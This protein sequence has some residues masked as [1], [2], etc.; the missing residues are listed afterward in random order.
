MGETARVLE[1]IWGKWE[2]KYFSEN[3]KYDLTA[4]STKPPDGQINAVMRGIRA[5]IGCPA[6][7]VRYQ[8]QPGF[9]LRDAIE[10]RSSDSFRMSVID[11]APT[12]AVPMR[13]NCVGRHV[14]R[15]ATA[16]PSRPAV[17]WHRALPWAAW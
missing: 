17:P 9:A 10:D 16:P 12:F 15:R 2:W 4:L 8:G 7:V 14:R 1:V 3:Q 11:P 13:A 5:A 6:D